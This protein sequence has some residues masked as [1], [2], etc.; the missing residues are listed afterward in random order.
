[1][2]VNPY[3]ILGWVGIAIALIGAFV[4]IPY[5]GAILLVLGLIGGYAIA[6]ED[7]VRVLVTAL[8][9]AGLSGQFMNLPELGEPLA[10]IFSNYA[11]AVAGA[12]LMIVTK[13]V[14]RRFKP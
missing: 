12:A 4:D 8:V 11:I 6:A 9:L 14:W 1:M 13:N 5:M 3:K 10:R 7:H 2:T